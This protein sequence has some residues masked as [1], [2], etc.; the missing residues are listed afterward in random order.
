METLSPANSPEYIEAEIEV[1][2]GEESKTLS[3]KE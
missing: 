1:K 3:S 2:E